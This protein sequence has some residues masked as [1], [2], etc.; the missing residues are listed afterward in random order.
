M[1]NHHWSF[2][3]ANLIY[4]PVHVH[5]TEAI[6]QFR[7]S[8]DVKGRALNNRYWLLRKTKDEPIQLFRRKCYIGSF[9]GKKFFISEDAKIFKDELYKELP[10]LKEKYG[11]AQ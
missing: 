5:L 10:I 4:K 11:Y 1:H 7:S 9:I 2:E 3:I 6:D 8:E